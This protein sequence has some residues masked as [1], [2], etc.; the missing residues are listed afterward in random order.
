VFI[1]F[2]SVVQQ[3]VSPC[4]YTDLKFAIGKHK[5]ENHDEPSDL[6]VRNAIALL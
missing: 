5:A 6:N 3:M 1:E 2:S 4:P